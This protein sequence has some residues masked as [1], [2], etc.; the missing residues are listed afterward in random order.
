[1]LRPV[2]DSPFDHFWRAQLRAQ[3]RPNTANTVIGGAYLSA[4]N[5]VEWS[6]PERVLQNAVQTH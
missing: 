1:M 2:L 6:I 4:Q 3:I 5:V